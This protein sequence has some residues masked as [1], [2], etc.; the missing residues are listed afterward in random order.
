[1]QSRHRAPKIL[2]QHHPVLE[3]KDD[4]GEVE[5][6]NCSLNWFNLNYF[7]FANFI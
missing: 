5:M 7:T 2:L 3:G 6:E 1:M 4:G